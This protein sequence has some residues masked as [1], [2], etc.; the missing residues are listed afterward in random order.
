MR[1]AHTDISIPDFTPYRRK[2]TQDPTSKA[3]DNLE[4][5]QSFTYLVAGGKNLEFFYNIVNQNDTHTIL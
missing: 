2:E 4:S 1:F 5:R 3:K